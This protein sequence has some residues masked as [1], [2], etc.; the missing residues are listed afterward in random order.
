MVN[1][2][3]C[4]KSW[5]PIVCFAFTT[6]VNSSGT[7]SGAPAT[8]NQSVLDGSELGAR[9]LCFP[10]CEVRVIFPVL[11]LPRGVFRVWRS[12]F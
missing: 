5:K 8:C 12:H 1:L 3:F 6:L 7:L 11:S 9:G 2:L 4:M 10:I